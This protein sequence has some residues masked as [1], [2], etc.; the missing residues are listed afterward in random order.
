M[1]LLCTD[2]DLPMISGIATISAAQQ[3]QQQQQQQQDSGQKHTK[4]DS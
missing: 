3:Q 4:L 1:A 2:M